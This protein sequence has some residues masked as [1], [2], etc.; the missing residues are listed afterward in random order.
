MEGSLVMLYG[1]T[2]VSI[3]GLLMGLNILFMFTKVNAE[4]F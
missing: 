4:M 1:D 2:G 3:I